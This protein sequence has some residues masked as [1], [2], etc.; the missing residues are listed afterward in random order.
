ML[1]ENNFDE[2]TKVAQYN[3][4]VRW[5][6]GYSIKKVLEAKDLFKNLQ[7]Y[8]DA[9]LMIGYCDDRVKALR[10]RKK[11]GVV[12]TIGILAIALASCFHIINS[13]ENIPKES[14]EIISDETAEVISVD[15][16]NCEHVWLPATI[17]SCKKCS[18]C[19]KRD[20]SEP[21]LID[22]TYIYV[23]TAAVQ[24]TEIKIDTF[25]DSFLI[26]EITNNF[27]EYRNRE[28]LASGELT[29]VSDN[30]LTGE[31]GYTFSFIEDEGVLYA[32]PLWPYCRK[33]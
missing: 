8:K 18:L 20:N 21:A 31:G 27:G 14:E 17:T 1:D 24:Y 28:K 7:G 26:Y 2:L 6:K 3:N 19:G 23:T 25:R 12:I 30:K 10:K 29:V 33:K 13:A 5:A 16:E 32:G 4:A 9:T 11:V 15:M 22:G